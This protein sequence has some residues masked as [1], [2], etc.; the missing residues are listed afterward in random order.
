MEIL[1]NILT[2]S[3]L[4][5]MFLLVND[6]ILNVKLGSNTGA[7]IGTAIGICQGDYLSALLFILYLAY[8]IKPIP[9]ERLP[10]DYRK[11]LWSALDWIVNRDKANIEIDPKYADDITFIRSEEVKI[12]QVES[13]IPPMLLEEGINKSKTE[14]FHINKYGDSK[15]K[16]CSKYHGSLVGTEDDIKRR[17]GLAHDSYKTLEK[18]LESTLVSETVRI[19]VFRAYTET[20]LLYNSELWTLTKTLENSI[21]AFHRRLLRKV[22]HVR[23]PRIIKNEDLYERTGLIPLSITICKRR[24]TWFGHLL[25]LPPE[26]PARRSLEA[27][28]RTWKRSAGKP[29]TT[30]LSIVMNDINIHSEIDLTGDKETDIR[31]LENL[32]T[33]RTAWNKTVGCIISSKRMNMQ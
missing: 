5:M 12:N 33:D 10:E 4:Y 30:W 11:P 26:T 15:W 13:V 14:K 22:I 20:I 8:A 1:K 2:P 18:I 24:L 27:F 3:E 9:D 28:L 16:S 6:V 7:D 17:K 23:W 19:R 21:N 25:R 32:C 31:H 29:K